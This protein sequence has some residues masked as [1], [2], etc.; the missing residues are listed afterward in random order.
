MKQIWQR[1]EMLLISVSIYLSHFISSGLPRN[2]SSR[3][4]SHFNFLTSI[5]SKLPS[6]GGRRSAGAVTDLETGGSESQ[7]MF[8]C[9]EIVNFCKQQKVNCIREQLAS[10]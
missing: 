1:A 9:E 3:S 6:L 10:N 2:P 5:Q 4:L 7:M 8:L